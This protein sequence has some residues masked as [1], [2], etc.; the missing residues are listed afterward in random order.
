MPHS[1]PH[2]FLAPA[3]LQAPHIPHTFS[4]PRYLSS[5]NS[6]PHPPPYTRHTSG[7]THSS[8]LFQH[9]V[10]VQLRAPPD[11][12][13][14]DAGNQLLVCLLGQQQCLEVT[15]FDLRQRLRENLWGNESNKAC[16]SKGIW[17]L[18]TSSSYAPW[19][20][21]SV[22][23]YLPRSEIQR[24]REGISRGAVTR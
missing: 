19:T 4:S 16:L 21:E 9:K 3:T 5:R 22:L 20:N 23:R 15:S 6:N 12:V 17:M 18:A 13:L 7:P 1:Y 24:R 8:H 10:F 11:P 2:A 14:I